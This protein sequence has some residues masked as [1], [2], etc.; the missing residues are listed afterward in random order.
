[1]F[2]INFLLFLSPIFQSHIQRNPFS[3]TLYNINLDRENN[4]YF[5][6]QFNKFHNIQLFRFPYLIL[7]K[8]NSKLYTT[9][10]VSHNRKDIV[11]KYLT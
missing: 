5:S 7:S 6:Y 4:K 11:R 9:Q 8:R 1:M 10:N 3:L 2:F